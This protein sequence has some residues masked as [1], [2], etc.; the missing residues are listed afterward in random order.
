MG[1]KMKRK[2][3]KK[4]R[5]IKK[6]RIIILLLIV[7]IIVNIVLGVCKESKFRL[8]EKNDNNKFS[9]TQEDDTS[10]AQ[11]E[12]IIERITQDNFI[13]ELKNKVD[14]PETFLGFNVIAKLEIPKINLE[15]FILENYEEKGMKVCASKFWGPNPNE[16]G[17]FCIAGHNYE[18]ER[19]FNHLIDLEV[20]DELFL[21]DNINGKKKYTIY[22]I[23]KVKPQNTE[24]LEQETSGEIRVTLIT[25]VNYSQ[26][27][28]IVQAR[29]QL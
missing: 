12:V 23:Y 27:R 17:N 6:I 22:D 2:Q 4:I 5:L 1:R 28:L 18:Q 11:K 21:S 3:E 20:G 24:P 10:E 19:M 15:T 9:K 13:N 7:G 16:I 25:C 14:L 29:S 26:N 8:V